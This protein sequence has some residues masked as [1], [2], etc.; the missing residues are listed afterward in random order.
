MSVYEHSPRRYLVRHAP[1]SVRVLVLKR[2]CC[3]EDERRPLS[4]SHQ[5]EEDAA[6]LKTVP[7]AVLAH[8]AAG[9]PEPTS[10]KHS[11]T[12]NLLCDAN[13]GLLS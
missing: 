5:R 2:P 11:S 4:R 12:A 1:I 3:E 10:S 13:P 6:L 8:F 9:T 7:P